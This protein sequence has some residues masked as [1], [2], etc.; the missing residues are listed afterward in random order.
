M[1]ESRCIMCGN[2]RQ[3]LEVR[4]DYMIDTIRWF[5]RNVTKSEKGYGLVVCRDCFARYD[6]LRRSYQRRQAMYV[7]LGIIFALAL[8][9]VAG[10][11]LLSALVYGLL[12][13]AFMY[14]LAQL[15]YMPALRMPAAKKQ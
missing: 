10:P 7:A 4:P 6:K 3:G 9:A 1:K 14:L 13:I 12:I 11:R 5:K 15:S 8:V 2:P